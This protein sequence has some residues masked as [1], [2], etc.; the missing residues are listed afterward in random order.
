[1]IPT[2]CEQDDPD[3][4]CYGATLEGIAQDDLPAPVNTGYYSSYYTQCF[5][6]AVP[7]LQPVPEE[8]VNEGAPICPAFTTVEPD[9]CDDDDDDDQ[10]PIDTPKETQ[11]PA[12]GDPVDMFSGNAFYNSVDLKLGKGKYPYS[13]SFVRNYNSS[14]RYSDGPLGF[15]WTH[16]FATE[17]NAGSNGLRVA[18]EFSPKEA[19][20][21]IAHA[22]VL[23][24]LSLSTAASTN[25]LDILIAAWGTQWLM[26]AIFLNNAVTISA[27]GQSGTFV[28]LVDSSYNP[29]PGSANTLVLNADGTFSVS[30]P[31]K[32]TWNFNAA[33]SMDT[34]VDPSGVTVT[35]SYD[36]S[37][38]VSSVTNG[39]NRTIS[40]TYTDDQLTSVSDGT[41]RSVSY[42]VDTSGN[43][44]AFTDAEDNTTTYDYLSPS[45]LA[46]IYLPANPTES[47]FTNSY[48]SLARVMSQSRSNAGTWN[49]FFAGSRSEV[50]DPAGNSH[51][52]YLDPIGCLVSEINE[53][54]Q[55]T[56]YSRDGMFRLKK[57]LLPEQNAIEL[58]YDNNNN[59]LT[60]T[61]VAKPGSG[62]TNIVNQF[63]Y[64][65]QWAKVASFTDGVG[66]VTNFTYDETQG[67]LL[68]IV[69]P[70][71]G[72]SN[73]TVN[74]TYNGRGQVLTSTDETGIVDSFAYS[75]S[76]ETLL[77]ITHD[78]GRLNLGIALAY[79]SVGNIN[80]VTDPNSNTTKCRS[81]INSDK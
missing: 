13:L 38:R 76:D 1:M 77:S 54:N 66:N 2:E 14:N 11:P 24:Q 43:L 49:Y 32:K 58:T 81:Q 34:Y 41:G 40:L 59:V 22:F 9:G 17:L 60:V 19:A 18:G 20:A 15:G 64:D 33:G 63:T 21:T 73:P 50:V 28:K 78:S 12:D 55:Q 46:N 16:N 6:T 30:N 65:S 51:V 79:D 5:C 74:L 31:W 71:I 68:T 67:T 52:W 48:D 75:E 57:T 42:V 80:S 45:L 37:G 61:W 4:D 7:N 35:F 3:V 47:I 26:D 56:H 53:L 39:L 36:E 29:P 44:T 62:L 10:S 69:R 70:E 72:G 8:D 23:S 27:G 25:P